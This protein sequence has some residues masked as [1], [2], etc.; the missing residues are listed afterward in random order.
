MEKRPAEATLFRNGRRELCPHAHRRELCPHA[1]RGRVL[2]A[3]IQDVAD[4][5]G[6]RWLN[7]SWSTMNL[8]LGLAF[9]RKPNCTNMHWMFTCLFQASSFLIGYWI[10]FFISQPNETAPCSE[11]WKLVFS[12]K[13]N[14]PPGY[15]LTPLQRMICSMLCKS[16]FIKWIR[17]CRF[18]KL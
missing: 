9:E 5:H 17:H 15:R 14:Y 1:H 12:I 13:S 8:H 6:P 11:F 16:I 3:Y 7:N 2:L 4:L 18:L 10:Y